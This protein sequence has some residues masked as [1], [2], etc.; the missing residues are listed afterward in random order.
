MFTQVII[1]SAGLHSDKIAQMLG[2]DI[3]KARYKLHYSK[4]EY[5]RVKGSKS[6]FINHLIYP[7]PEKTSLGI[8]TVTDLQGELK[9]GPSAFYVEEINYDV[10]P[11]HKLKFYESTKRFLPFIEPDDLNPDMASIRPKLQGLDDSPEDFVILH[12]EKKGL[13]GVIDLIGIDSP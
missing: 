5:F 11:S 13:P 6:K 10:N 7:T 12:E 4:G 9:L 3:E 1:N 2:I 8:H